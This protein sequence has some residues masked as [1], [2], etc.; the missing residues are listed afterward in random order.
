MILL[1][2]QRIDTVGNE[3]RGQHWSGK[4]ANHL[5]SISFV[6]QVKPCFWPSGRCNSL[7][8]LRSPAYLCRGNDKF[9]RSC[10]TIQ[11]CQ[12]RSSSATNHAHPALPTTLAPV[13]DLGALDT[14]CGVFAVAGVNHRVG[15][16][17]VKD[18]ALDI[19]DKLREILG[20]VRFADTAW[21]DAVTDE[22]VV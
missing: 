21:E 9:F 2:H 16:V 1:V 22:E 15:G 8:I 5:N 12:R 4:L 13:L 14:N 20:R 19:V 10:G 3:N 11:H 18:A 6:V 17:D 7:L